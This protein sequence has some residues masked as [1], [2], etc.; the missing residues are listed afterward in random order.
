MTFPIDDWGQWAMGYAVSK[1]T[2]TCIDDD[3]ALLTGRFK[4]KK[5][6]RKKKKK[7]KKKKLIIT[8]AGS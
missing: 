3:V 8:I 4:K 1:I 7:K 6:R 5:K 2:N